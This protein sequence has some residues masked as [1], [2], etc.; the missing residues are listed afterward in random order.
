[1][2]KLLLLLMSI[3][4]IFS[5]SGCGSSEKVISIYGVVSKSEI[6][7]MKYEYDKSLNI[8][9]LANALSFWSGANFYLKLVNQVKMFYMLIF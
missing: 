9:K 5:L 7:E 8:S 3:V 1:M 2:K 6:K 4:M